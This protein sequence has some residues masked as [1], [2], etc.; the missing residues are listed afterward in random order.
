MVADWLNALGVRP[1]AFGVRVD[2]PHS[3]RVILNDNKALKSSG[4][5]LHPM[6]LLQAFLRDVFCF[7]D[8]PLMV[9]NLSAPISI[10]GAQQTPNYWSLSLRF[11]LLSWPVS[12][13]N[14]Y[15][16]ALP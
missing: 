10:Y 15:A 6:A 2:S 7:I 3:I 1:R 5:E 14:L 16:R 11:M 9:A 13:T 12:V 4:V 8:E